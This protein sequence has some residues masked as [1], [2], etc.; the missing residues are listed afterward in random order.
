MTTARAVFMEAYFASP[1]RAAIVSADPRVRQDRDVTFGLVVAEGTTLRTEGLTIDAQLNRLDGS[2]PAVPVPFR[3]YGTSGDTTAGG[4]LDDGDGL[5]DRID[6]RC[7]SS[8]CQCV[9]C[10]CASGVAQL[11]YLCCLR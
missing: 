6:I 5:F 3:D 1:L 2:A 10:L 7:G 9:P 11:L 8:V 4:R